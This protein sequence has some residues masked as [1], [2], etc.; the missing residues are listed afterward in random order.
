MFTKLEGTLMSIRESP[1]TRFQY[2]VW[3]DYTREAINGIHEG[4]MLAVAN[5][6]S[7][8]N[9]RKW[10][11]LEVTSVMPSHFALQGGNAGYPGFV[12]EAAR[13]AA[14]DWE[15]QDTVATEETTKIEVTA[16]P[17]FLEIVEPASGSPSIASETNMAMVGSKV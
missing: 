16:I 3:F 13:S 5:F 17:T 6:G 11:V 12:V 1:D 2:T 9:T 10:S 8:V 4:T 7:D 14:Q 15:S